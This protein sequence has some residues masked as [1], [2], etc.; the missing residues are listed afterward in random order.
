MTDSDTF[1]DPG[2]GMTEIQ[3]LLIENVKRHRSRLGLTQ[4]KLAELCDLSPNFISSVESGKK[5]PSI[6]TMQKLVDALDIKPYQLLIDDRDTASIGNLES[7]TRYKEFLHDT[8]GTAINESLDKFIP[9]EEK[10]EQ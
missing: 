3:S 9:G 8:V 1:T 2:D 7:L 10:G 4:S 6:E 5:I